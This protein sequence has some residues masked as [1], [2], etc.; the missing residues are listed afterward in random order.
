M[1][2]V[3]LVFI[4]LGALLVL[5]STEWLSVD[6]T[7]LLLIAA[8]M[9]SG[10]LSPEEALAGFGDA[11]VLTLAALFILAQILVRSGVIRALVGVL[12]GPGGAGRVVLPK[13]VGAA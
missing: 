5:F 10:L 13:A 7:A 12:A 9:L 11:T 8:L 2:P 4:L 3:S 6:V 1:D